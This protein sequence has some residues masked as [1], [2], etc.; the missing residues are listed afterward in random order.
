[1][2]IALPYYQIVS[3]DN[4]EEEIMERNKKTKTTRKNKKRIYVRHNDQDRLSSG[5][6][7][8]EAN[9]LKVSE[10]DIYYDTA[11]TLLRKIFRDGIPLTPYEHLELNHIVKI[12]EGLECYKDED[13]CNARSCR[14][15]GIPEEWVKYEGFEFLC[16]LIYNY[17]DN[18]QTLIPPGVCDAMNRVYDGH[19]CANH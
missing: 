2:S 4:K 8:S 1:M 16:D 19:A 18:D 6:F 17:I 13:I 15:A 9:K 10:V 7:R 5:N 11:N 12:F 3:Q 14:F